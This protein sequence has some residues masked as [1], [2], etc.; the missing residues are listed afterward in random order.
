LIPRSGKSGVYGI[1]NSGDSRIYVGSAKDLYDRYSNH[2]LRLI[3]GDHYSEHL[4]SIHNTSPESLEF[5]VIEEIYDTAILRQREQFWIDFYQSYLP[6]KG[7]NKNPKS[8][9]PLGRKLT[10]NAKSKI[11]KSKLGKLNTK[12]SK[13]VIQ[14]SLDGEQISTFPSASEAG[15]RLQIP[16]SCIIN[17]IAGRNKKSGGFKWTYASTS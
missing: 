7:F 5:F 8:D 3:K 16:V 14:W 17:C 2:K 15:R 4:Q 11:G 10:E 12:I 6:E 9:S 13:P 1:I